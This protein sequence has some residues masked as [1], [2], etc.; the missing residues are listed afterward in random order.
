MQAQWS[1]I[2]GK[3]T[4]KTR[5][6]SGA[7]AVCTSVRGKTALRKRSAAC[8]GAVVV[9]GRPLLE[10]RLA[11]L[12]F[13]V[14]Q[15]SG[16][17]RGSKRRSRRSRRAARS[18]SR[19]SAAAAGP[20]E[21]RAA[22]SSSKPRARPASADAQASAARPN[23]ARQAAKPVCGWMGT[24]AALSRPVVATWSALVLPGVCSPARTARPFCAAPGLVHCK[25]GCCS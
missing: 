2:S 3:S 1:P 21:A 22:R 16:V 17:S 25:P 5:A 9:Q 15:F 19:R 20:K 18:R 8:A 13:R 7:S 4:H 24:A 23:R 14:V 10:Q 12:A 6:A 11:A